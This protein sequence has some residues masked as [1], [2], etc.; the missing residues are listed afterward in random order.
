[1]LVKCGFAAR[2]NRGRRNGLRLPTKLTDGVEKVIE[3]LLATLGV[4]T[5]EDIK[6]SPT[7][8]TFPKPRGGNLEARDT[9]IKSSTVG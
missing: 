3:M 8:R 1:M 5:I 6:R 9:P 4:I 7:T 2:G